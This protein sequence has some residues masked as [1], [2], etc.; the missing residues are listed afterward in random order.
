L[1]FKLAIKI[2]GDAKEE[3]EKRTKEKK[4]EEIV[5]KLQLETFKRAH[6]PAILSKKGKYLH[7]SSASLVIYSVFAL[8]LMTFC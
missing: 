7:V 1:C 6:K 2:G 4:E 5:P 8:E 3:V